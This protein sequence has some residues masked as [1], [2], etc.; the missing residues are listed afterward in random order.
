MKFSKLVKISFLAASIIILNACNNDDSKSYSKNYKLE[1]VK[2]PL[3]EKVN[4]KIMTQSSPIAPSDPNEKLIFKRLEEKLNL[5]VDWTNYTWDTYGEKRNLKVA[6]GELPDAFF[7]AG[8]SDSDILK[9]AA[10]GVIIP[11]EDLIDNYMP[12]LKAILDKKPE[13][14]KFITAPDGHIYTLP[15]IEELGSGKE[16]IQSTDTIPWIN[17]QWL[18]NLGLSMP[19][20]IDEFENVLRQFKDKDPDGDG[21]PNN[22]I[23]MSFIYNSGGE[24]MKSILG[25]FGYGDNWDH[26]VVN[27]EGKV[28]F[29]LS[30]S[31]YKE[32]IKWL[33]KLYKEKLIDVDVF[34][35][36]WNT[37]LAKGSKHQYGTYFT[38]DMGNITGFKSGDYSH[39]DKIEADYTAM[40]VLFGENNWKN[41]TRTN[42]F[43]LDRGKFA[44]S[45]KNQ[46]L[47]LTAKWIDQMYEPLQSTQNNWGTY[48]D[49][50]GPNIFELKN[51]GKMLAHLPL[52]GVSP[53]ELRQKTYV[54]G[55]LA[56]LDEYYG[57]S[58]TKPDDAAWRLN[59]LK[60]IYVPDMKMDNNY[61]KV[62]YTLEDQKKMTEIELELFQYATRT[63]AEMIQKGVTD[64]SWNNYLAELD[65]KG[66]KDWITIKQK[67]YDNYNK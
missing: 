15:W 63:M 54:G 34:S 23:P 56:V 41:I 43:G 18:K 22:E 67:Y 52:K 60:T 58:V 36:D 2:F 53:W 28:I 55:P 61:P 29:T 65:K 47:E 66:L 59:L 44:I 5:H 20:N 51:D 46:N 39:P 32:A 30:D 24:D 1:G 14:R 4:L 49:K 42:G 21:N 45:S 40:P 6:S 19:T 8:F 64:D 25:A 12:N 26:T 3:K 57:K 16:A 37:Y 35:Q 62:F 50:N 38:W 27:N 31:G 48:G 10:D 13:Y 9:Y 33:S 11:L 7:D 17:K